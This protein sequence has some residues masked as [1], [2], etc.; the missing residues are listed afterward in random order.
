MEHPVID[1]IRKSPDA[2]VRLYAL[3]G[4]AMHYANEIEDLMFWCYFASRGAP[5]VDAVDAFYD[6]VKFATKQ[7][8]TDAAVTA[9]VTGTEH[10]QTW[11]ELYR[12]IQALL[13]EGNSIRNL[14]GHNPVSH[15]L[16]AVGDPSRED[17][18]APIMIHMVH[19]VRQK[20]AMV[21]RRNRPQANIRETELRT[22]CEQLHDLFMALDGFCSDVLGFDAIRRQRREW[23][24]WG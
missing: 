7:D 3:M 13:G 16:Y 18:S 6:K 1:L 4:F 23:H 17:R 9:K 15:A 20:R 5:W 19:E 14:I 24:E 21:E 10:L 11:Q 22:Y 2:I 8:K 12:G